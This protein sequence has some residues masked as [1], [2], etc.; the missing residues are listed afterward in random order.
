MIHWLL[1]TTLWIW[2]IKAIFTYPFIFWKQG[3]WL[4]SNLPR[5]LVKPLISC[6]VCMPSIHGTCMFLYS[7]QT[8]VMNWIIFVI[9]LA[10]INYLIVEFLYPENNVEIL[11][12]E[13]EKPKD[14]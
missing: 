12:T 7:D 2:G 10:G 14:I 11:E 8:G 5:Y 13:Q 1:I 4:D 6:P 3:D 9:A